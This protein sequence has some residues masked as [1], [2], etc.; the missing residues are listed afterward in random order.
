MI[1]T[2]IFI[3]ILILPTFLDTALLAQTEASFSSLP[4]GIYIDTC[5]K[6]A[7]SISSKSQVFYPGESLQA[8]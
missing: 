5:E 3:C 1:C 6:I 4:R 8:I 2:A 7:G